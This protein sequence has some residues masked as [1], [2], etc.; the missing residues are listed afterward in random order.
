[1]I[2]GK[3]YAK[4]K[5]YKEYERCTPITEEEFIENVGYRINSTSQLH[6]LLMRNEKHLN[7]LVAVSQKRER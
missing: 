2:F 5:G 1:M 7:M 6:K 3:E 4:R